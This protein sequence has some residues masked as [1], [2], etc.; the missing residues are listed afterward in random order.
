MGPG[1]LWLGMERG[2][3]HGQEVVSLEQEVGELRGCRMIIQSQPEGWGHGEEVLKVMSL[4][5]APHTLQWSI[6]LRVR[7]TPFSGP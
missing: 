5:S 4:L 1:A 6:S 3:Q 2:M 7:A